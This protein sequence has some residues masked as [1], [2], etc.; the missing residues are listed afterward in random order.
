MTNI[1]H[2]SDLHGNY[3][4]ALAALEA[5]GFDLWI[6]SGDFF[7]N[8]TRGDWA[9]E[10]AFQTKWMAWK[11]LAARIVKALDGKTL[12]SVGGNHD[13]VSLASLVKAA[14]GNAHDLTEGPV[15]IN[16]LTFAG[17]SEVPW[18]AGEWNG[19]THAFNEIVDATF[20]AQPDVLVTHA[21]PAGVLDTCPDHGGG[22]AALMTALCYQAHEVKAHFFGHIHEFGGQVV[23][24]MG[25]Q[26]ANGAGKAIVHTI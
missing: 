7:P 16:G 11:D 13:Y 3:K 5:G 15:T 19:E 23:E 21:P 6:D 24:E 12:I 4:K 1:L 26:F 25:I 8:K 20:Q 17:F 2:T 10:P 14:G 22:I 18:M 9:I